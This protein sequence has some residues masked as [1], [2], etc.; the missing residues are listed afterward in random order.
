MHGLRG[1]GRDDGPPSGGRHVPERSRIRVH[2]ANVAVDARQ[3]RCDGGDG[4]S[5]IYSNP[6]RY[7][8]N[9]FFRAKVILLIL[10]SSGGSERD[11]F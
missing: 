9:L 6:V 8:H 7:Y 10:A 5:D 1:D 3:R 2:A 11:S 4:P